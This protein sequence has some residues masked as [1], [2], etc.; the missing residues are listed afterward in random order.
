MKD[1]TL[2]YT[3]IGS[4]PFKGETAPK[5]AIEAVFKNYEEIPF[6]PQLPNYSHDED[7]VI[8]Y[9]I[10]MAG[11]TTD[12]TKYYFNEESEEFAL[13][14]EEFYFDWEI[15]S[16]AESFEEC[17]E[18]LDKYAISEKSSSTFRLFLEKIKNNPKVKYAKG[19][20]TGA[21]TT[22]TSISDSEGKCAY[23]NEILRDIIAKTIALKAV[24][25]IKEIKKAN[26]DITPIIFMDEPSVSQLGSSA[27]L[28]VEDN[29]V[30]E[31]FNI[32]SS[33]I[34]KFNGIVGMHC[35]GKSNWEIPIKA[36]VDMINF[37]SYLY[38]QSVALHHKKIQEFLNDG[39]ILAFGI[40]P[41]MDDN[42]ILKITEEELIEKFESALNMFVEK[43]LNKEQI[44]KQSFITPSC[45]CGS[46]SIEGANKVIYHTKKLSENLR[47]KYREILWH[48][49]LQ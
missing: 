5:D 7:M 12:G 18:V 22:S 27:F 39:G 46:L 11:L 41:T 37:D 19:S 8:Q 25:Q 3:A 43:G 30:L 33:L 35:C 31:M 9:A 14:L 15:I 45:G 32:V 24:W 34:K 10:N 26:S 47:E 28:T 23:Y 40:I 42:L 16:N 17:E 38:P 4:L 44:I 48:Q 1:L 49:L 20:V 21:F 29:E 2:N 13:A 36:H 6:W